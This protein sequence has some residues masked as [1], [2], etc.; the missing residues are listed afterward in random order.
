MQ[1]AR[2]CFATLS[3]RLEQLA[4]LTIIFLEPCWVIY[5]G[6]NSYAQ[7][8]VLLFPDEA[9]QP[10]PHHG[11]RHLPY[12]ATFRN[13]LF[14]RNHAIIQGEDEYNPT[15]SFASPLRSRKVS[16]RT[17]ARVF[18]SRRDPSLSVMTG[19]RPMCFH[20]LP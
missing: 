9:S 10:V 7:S 8:S 3:H 16:T 20:F 15:T 14:G 1:H 18:R 11:R 4:D 2:E 19:G 17:L 5:F 13:R 6:V 12:D